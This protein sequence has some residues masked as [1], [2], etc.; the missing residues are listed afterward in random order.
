[1]SHP[2]IA[3]AASA[4][5]KSS[6]GADGRVRELLIGALALFALDSDL[7]PVLRESVQPEA[8]LGDNAIG[9]L[10]LLGPGALLLNHRNL[11]FE[12]DH[13]KV[14]PHRSKARMVKWNH[15]SF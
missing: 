1:M 10:G 7:E 11:G 9:I 4:D 2:G 5:E 6:S 8:D 15:R 12:V 14:E 3:L 13:L